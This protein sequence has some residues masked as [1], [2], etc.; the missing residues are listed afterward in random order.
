MQNDPNKREWRH[1]LTFWHDAPDWDAFTPADA[2]QFVLDRGVSIDNIR[3]ISYPGKRSWFRKG[4]G[5]EVMY[6]YTTEAEYANLG[7][8]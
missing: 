5:R 6:V 4:P 2:Q 3:V 1:Y 7:C 8:Y